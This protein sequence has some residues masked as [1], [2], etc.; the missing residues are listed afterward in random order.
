MLVN[1]YCDK[2]QLGVGGT[3][4]WNS[5]RLSPDGSGFKNIKDCFAFCGVQRTG[6]EVGLEGSGCMWFIIPKRRLVLSTL[7]L[8]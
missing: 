1:E 3:R 6:L 5:S 7:Y 2:Q 8:E 4:D